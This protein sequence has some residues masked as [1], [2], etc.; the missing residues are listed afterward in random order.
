MQA[1]GYVAKFEINELF[2]HSEVLERAATKQPDHWISRKSVYRTGDAYSG[3]GIP[4]RLVRQAFRQFY[5]FNKLRAIALIISPRLFTPFNNLRPCR[6][7]QRFEPRKRVPSRYRR[8]R[9]TKIFRGVSKDGSIF[10]I[11]TGNRLIYLCSGGAQRNFD[12]RQLA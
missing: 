2:G 6:I 8:A 9:K 5:Q 11:T 7:C 10:P 3:C 1:D 12:P 4:G